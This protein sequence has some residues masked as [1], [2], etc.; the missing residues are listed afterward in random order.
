MMMVFG[1]GAAVGGGWIQW[2]V[3]SMVVQQY[4]ALMIIHF[5]YDGCYIYD[6]YDML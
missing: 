4:L 3:A 5:K 2:W 6:Y 1:A